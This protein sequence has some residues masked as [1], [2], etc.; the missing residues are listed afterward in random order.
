M[1]F[2]FSFVEN[3]NRKWSG[4]INLIEDITRIVKDDNRHTVKIAIEPVQLSIYLSDDPDDDY[5]ELYVIPIKYD[6]LIQSAYIDDHDYKKMMT[7]NDGG[8]DLE[9]IKLIH[10]IM[11]YLEENKESIEDYMNKLSVTRNKSMIPETVI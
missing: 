8:I 10:K 1:K 4:N 11:L 2:V 3:N 5:E 9:E 7:D 6:I